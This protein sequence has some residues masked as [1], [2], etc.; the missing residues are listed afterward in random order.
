MDK[1]GK[2]YYLIYSF[3]RN[4][5]GGVALF[6]CPTVTNIYANGQIK[7]PDLYLLLIIRERKPPEIIL[8]RYFFFV[9]NNNHNIQ[10]ISLNLL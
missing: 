10:H 5:R 3:G 6:S 2:F 4:V 8:T 7:L 9:I 1:S